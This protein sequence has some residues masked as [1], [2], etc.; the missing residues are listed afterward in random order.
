MTSVKSSSIV[1]PCFEKC[2]FTTIFVVRLLAIFIVCWFAFFWF[3]TSLSIIHS[4]FLSIFFKQS[5]GICHYPQEFH[6]CMVL[7]QP[8]PLRATLSTLKLWLYGSIIIRQNRSWRRKRTNL[9]HGRWQWFARLDKVMAYRLQ[10]LADCL[11]YL[12]AL[13]SCQRTLER[14]KSPIPLL[15]RMER[16][17]WQSS[18]IFSFRPTL[19]TKA[20]FVAIFRKI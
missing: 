4:P 20:W 5:N 7:M 14:R 10:R 12:T 18:I 3:F 6:L 11:T 13:F 15:V 19:D 9:P 17:K 16:I 1:F 8:Y 2:S